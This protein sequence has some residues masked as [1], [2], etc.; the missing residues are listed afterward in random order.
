M[1]FAEAQSLV[2][3]TIK[4]DSLLGVYPSLIN[5]AIRDICGYRSWSFMRSILSPTISTGS[6]SVVIGDN[7]KELQGG[8]TPV[9]ART[10]VGS[11][12][13]PVPFRVR[14]RMEL[15][16]LLYS[17][18]GANQFTPPREYSLYARDC[19]VEQV[20]GVWT[21]GVPYAIGT[22]A[23]TLDVKCYTYPVDLVNDTDTNWFL[24]NIPMIVLNKSRQLALETSEDEKA[25]DRAPKFEAIFSRDLKRAT[26]ED[27]YRDVAGHTVR[28]GG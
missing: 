8:H 18:A 22:S 15:E 27:A 25:I 26:A 10:V 28:S 9:T 16:R 17:T 24:S 12:P 14:S 21:I 11:T 5:Q 3:V 6:A 20:S 23:L 7:F 19:W 13:A 4:E 2:H 1:N